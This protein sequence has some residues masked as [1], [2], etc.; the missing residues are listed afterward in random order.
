MI[1]FARYGRGGGGRIGPQ[2]LGS[3]P[4]AS[5]ETTSQT[6]H[7][8]SIP[9]LVNDGDLMVVIFSA[10]ISSATISWPGGW[11]ELDETSNG[12]SNVAV[13]YKVASG[14]GSTITVTTSVGTPSEH[15]AFAYSNAYGVPEIATPATGS[16]TTPNPPSLSPSWGEKSCV[17]IAYSSNDNGSAT[18]TSS[19]PAGYSNAGNIGE[20]VHTVTAANIAVRAATED[21]GTFTMNGTTPWIAGTIAIRG[22]GGR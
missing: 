14:E 2:V 9:S 21:P 5:E 15:I 8:V 18:N 20:G 6:S 3:V 1:P 10:Q 4:I 22:A 17:F 7:T 13:A 12:S 16:S 19:Y 11:T